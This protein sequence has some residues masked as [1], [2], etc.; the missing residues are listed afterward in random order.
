MKRVVL[1]RSEGGPSVVA[2]VTPPPALFLLPDLQNIRDVSHGAQPPRRE[3]ESRDTLEPGEVEIAE[4]F[5]SL[6]PYPTVDGD[7]AP[8]L[9]ALRLDSPPGGFKF[10]IA[11]Y[12][13]NVET[14]MHTTATFDIDVVLAGEIAIMTQDGGEVSLK[15]GDSVVIPGVAHNWRSG[16]E[17]CRVAF[18][19]MGAEPTD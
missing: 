4:V 7:T 11:S 15:P 12:G 1:G 19:M 16:P 9:D 14:S 6:T 13:P 5:G 18:F 8:T 10:R 2:S 3:A 17:G